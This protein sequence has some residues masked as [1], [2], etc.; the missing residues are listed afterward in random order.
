MSA[1]VNAWCLAMVGLFYYIIAPGRVDKSQ[2]EYVIWGLGAVVGYVFFYLSRRRFQ[3]LD[4]PGYW[5]RILA[6]PIPGVVLL[7]LL[8][9]LSAP[10][11]RNSFGSPPAPSRPLKVIL[12]LVCFVAALVF[13][14]FVVTLYAPLELHSAF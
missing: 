1:A 2:A 8:C 5:A 14:P 12:A 11:F 3:D 4:C 7:P 9:F 13:V 10:R 6:F